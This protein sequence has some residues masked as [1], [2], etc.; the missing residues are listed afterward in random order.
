MG[1]LLLTKLLNQREREKWKAQWICQSTRCT[2]SKQSASTTNTAKSAYKPSNLKS[3]KS[4][5]YCIRGL[6][7]QYT[8]MQRLP[9]RLLLTKLLDQRGCCGK[10]K[11]GTTTGVHTRIRIEES[12]MNLQINS[13]YCI[14]ALGKQYAALP[15]VP[16]SLPCSKIDKSAMYC[17]QQLSSS[18]RTV[19]KSA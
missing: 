19:Q 8:T 14:Q 16:T 9:T 5:V 18:T 6:G 10:T 2:A 15:R 12:P 17:I 4:A 1:R 11:W 3:D 7:K 13:M